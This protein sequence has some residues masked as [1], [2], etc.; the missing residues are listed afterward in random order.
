MNQYRPGGVSREYRAF[1]ELDHLLFNAFISLD[2]GT[3][4]TYQI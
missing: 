1:T 2:N 4:A 3:M